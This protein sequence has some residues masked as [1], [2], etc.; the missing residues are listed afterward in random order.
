MCM[1]KIYLHDYGS[2]HGT[3]I[4]TQRLE[5]YKDYSINDNDIVTFGVRITSGARMSCA[6]TIS[7]SINVSRA[8]S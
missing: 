2:T 3:Y 6:Y 4:G 7:I 5:S 1:Q 8:D